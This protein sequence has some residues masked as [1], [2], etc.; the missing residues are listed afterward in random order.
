L[1]ASLCE[2]DAESGANLFHG[3]LISALASWVLQTC[4]KHKITTVAL[5]GGCLLN[6]ILS[7]GLI[8]KLQQGGITPYLNQQAPLNDGGLSLGQAWVAAQILKRES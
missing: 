2:K 5:S 4:E 3:T 7:Q 1:L 6:Q 8:S